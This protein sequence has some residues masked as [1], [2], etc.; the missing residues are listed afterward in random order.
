MAAVIVPARLE[1]HTTDPPYNRDDGELDAEGEDDPDIE[2]PTQE[3]AQ[4]EVAEDAEISD[5]VPRE[6]TEEEEE[7]ASEEVEK[8]RPS[9]RLSKG[10]QRATSDDEAV[11]SAEEEAESSAAEEEGSDKESSDAESAAVADWEGGSEGGEDAEV[12]VANRNNCM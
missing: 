2:Y 5:A 8:P 1:A 12:E 3:K 6:V 10:K 4:S 7:D 11:V 9:R